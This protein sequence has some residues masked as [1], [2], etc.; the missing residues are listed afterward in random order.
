[1]GV[2]EI[3][4]TWSVSEAEIHRG[5]SPN[6]FGRQGFGKSTKSRLQK[7][8]IPGAIDLKRWSE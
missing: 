3:F 4:V 5:G 7:P 6:S 1:M 8:P 2:D